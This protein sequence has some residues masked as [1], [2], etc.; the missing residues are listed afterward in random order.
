MPGFVSL[1]TR[2]GEL[3]GC[4]GTIEPAKNSLAEE[5]AANAVSAAI[6]DPRFDPVREDEL[7]NLVY[8]VDVLLRRSRRQSK[9]SIRNCLA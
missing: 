2:D 6:S 5:I 1:K 8:S 9:T 3:R 4:I 7:A